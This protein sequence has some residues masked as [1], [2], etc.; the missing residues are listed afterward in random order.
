MIHAQVHRTGSS[1]LSDFLGNWRFFYL[2]HEQSIEALDPEMGSFHIHAPK[3]TTKMQ[4]VTGHFQMFDNESQPQP[5]HFKGLK[6]SMSDKSS[7]W[8]IISLETTE[9]DLPEQTGTT[10]YL[11]KEED[12]NGKPF[13]ILYFKTGSRCVGGFCLGTQA[14]CLNVEDLTKLGFGLTHEEVKERAKASLKD[15]EIGGTTASITQ[16]Q[17]RAPPKE[18]EDKMK[19][20]SLGKRDA[21]TDSSPKGALATQEGQK[22]HGRAVKRQKVAEKV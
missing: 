14:E 8:E 11:T 4:E 21:T 15:K 20:T 9:D 10:I 7:G 16:G 1:D 17:E 22:G 3:P 12:H 18:S 6:K 19:E 5:W 2:G 13:L